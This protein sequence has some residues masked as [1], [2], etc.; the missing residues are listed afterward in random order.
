MSRRKATR[1][2]LPPSGPML[3][4]RGSSTTQNVI[5]GHQL[6]QASLLTNTGPTTITGGNFTQVI[7]SRSEPRFD[8]DESQF[9]LVKWGHI[10]F[11]KQVGSIATYKQIKKRVGRSKTILTGQMNMHHVKVFPSSEIFTLVSYDRNQFERAKSDM[12]G[13]Q[14]LRFA[15]THLFDKLLKLQKLYLSATVVW[16]HKFKIPIWN[17]LS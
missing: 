11:I 14:H 16:S 9:E 5:G 17:P 15:L 2:A 7:N 10:K 13:I 3:G 8:D 12:I 1:Q 6:Q 4:R